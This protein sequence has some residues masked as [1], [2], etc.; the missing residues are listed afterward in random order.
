LTQR[1]DQRIFIL[2][3]DLTGSADAAS[4]FRSERRRVRVTFTEEAPW[5]FTLGGDVVQ[6]FDTESRDLAADQ[7][8]RR[9]ERAAIPLARRSKASLIFKKVDSTLRGNLGVE[10]DT[11]LRALRRPL[12]V[13]AP[14][15]PAHRRA[16][17]GGRLLVD[18]IPITQVR[19]AHD[20]RRPVRADRVARVLAETSHLPI[21]EVGLDAVRRGSSHLAQTL[22]DLA[23]SPGIAVCDAETEE[24][25]ALVA[26]ASASSL[27]FLPCGSAGLARALARVWDDGGDAPPPGPAG[28]G[29]PGPRCHDALVAVGSAN[30]VA[31]EQLGVLQRAT[32][33]PV[34]ALRPNR[35]ADPV[36]RDAE[37]NRARE[38]VLRSSERILAVAIAPGAVEGTPALARFEVDLARVGLAWFERGKTSGADVR[39]LVC[40]GGA[41]ALALAHALEAVALWPE[42]EVSPGVPWSWMEG[43]RSRVL[44][45][46]KAGGF[47]G[48]TALLDAVRFLVEETRPRRP[49]VT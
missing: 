40:T 6:V 18:G 21:H 47:G 27:A 35:L 29:L 4:Y 22:R 44:L 36:S 16:V 24:D 34:V 32:G 8:R 28:G 11:A 31:H 7:A 43:V 42:G 48:P 14:A 45:V 49:E 46:T 23:A 3:D 19:G 1:P 30:S 9:I 20:P 25:L 10:I 12:A 37:V 15:L 41:T 38:Q 33:I 2:A 26:T 39:G 13:L 17:R 5:D